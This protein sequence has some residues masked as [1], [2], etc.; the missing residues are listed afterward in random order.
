MRSFICDKQG[1]GLALE[2]GGLGVEEEVGDGVG[3]PNIER[4]IVV[5]RY[6]TT[7]S[8]AVSKVL[9]HSFF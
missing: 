2:G 7:A 1:R 3:T 4:S 9:S 8:S 5:H 6:T